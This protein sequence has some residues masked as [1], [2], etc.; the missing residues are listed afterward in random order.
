[1]SVRNRAVTVLA[2]TL[3]LV[4][5]GLFTPASTATGASGGPPCV[6]VNATCYP[7]LDDAL[8][9]AEDGDTVR[10][11][12][13]VFPGGARITTSITLVGAGAGK[14]VIR[15]GE[16]VLTVGEPFEE[17]R[18]SV[19]IEKLTLT[20]GFARSSEYINAP[21]DPGVAAAGGGL[22]IP[23]GPDYGQ[24]STV[25][26][27][28][29]IVRD[30]RAAP[31]AQYIDESAP[32]GEWP[33]CPDGLCPFA[34][35][36]G[37]GIS[38]WGDLTLVR[39]VVADNIA[40]GE[41][42]SD[43]NGAGIWS[44]YPLTLRHSR[45]VDNKA[46][47][48]RTWGRY[49]EGGGIFTADALTLHNSSV[50]DNTAGLRS[51]FPTFLEDGT[52]LDMLA[53]GGGILATGNYP[54]TLRSSRVDR[55]RTFIDAPNAEWGVIN[56]GLFVGD[57]PLTMRESSVS[58]N[59]AHARLLHAPWTMGGAVEWHSAA[60]VR[61]SRFVGNRSITVASDGDAR[62]SGAVGPLGILAFESD[63]GLSVMRD[64]LIS[65]NV[66]MSVARDGTAFVY[67]AGMTIDSRVR[68]DRVR[69]SENR[70]V[71][72]G[73]STRVEGG[74]IWNGAL[75]DFVPDPPSQLTLRESAVTHNILVGGDGSR[76]GGGLFTQVPVTIEGST[77]AG[78]VPDQCFGCG[79]ETSKTSA[80]ERVRQVGGRPA[81]SP[82]L[83]HH[84]VWWR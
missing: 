39:T 3:G 54:V 13:G 78:N 60:D 38:N 56:A 33:V 53:N 51:D 58:H 84:R 19:R 8:A 57:G 75:D 6:K 37:A 45:V 55:N 32:P 79:S 81:V 28:D 14:T 65:K 43:V 31:S 46:L 64:S 40:S 15:G 24:G 82:Q 35:A 41:L 42:A 16:H 2:A 11:P 71:A 23:P 67:G 72:I 52:Y 83:A 70:A 5:T 20:G 10:L 44:V 66:S 21:L 73:D 4:A 59:V 47:A 30:N 18:L 80:A 50:V 76:L 34:S 69:V 9:A 74:G 63:P 61:T 68:L 1:M 17:D 36:S 22:E 29:V 25:V 48:A 26:V 27:S 62:T 12:A 77:V 7:S 49:A